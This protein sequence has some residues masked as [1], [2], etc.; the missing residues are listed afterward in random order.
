MVGCIHL[1]PL[2][3]S[4]QR[5]GLPDKPSQHNVLY[6]MDSLKC[7]VQNSVVRD[8]IIADVRAIV[9]TLSGMCVTMSHPGLF[10]SR[11]V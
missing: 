10:T 7:R 1:I 6:I 9:A 5:T 4:L 8:F 11:V 2:D 3:P